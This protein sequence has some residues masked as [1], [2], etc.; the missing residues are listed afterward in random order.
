[1]AR[2]VE[3]LVTQS[4][5]ER[6]ST[7]EDWPATRTQSLRMLRESLKRDMEWLLNTRRSVIDGS[8]QFEAVNRSVIQY[9]LIDTSSL[10]LSSTNDHKRLQQAVQQCIDDFEP[11]LQNTQVTLEADDLK[12]RKLR[13][14]IEGQIRLDPAPEEITFDTVLDLTSGE[15]SVS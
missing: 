15:Y 9:G 3:M 4:I 12:R 1:M 2:S 13:F 10:S 5:V 8:E 6:L 11:R 7:G 14:R